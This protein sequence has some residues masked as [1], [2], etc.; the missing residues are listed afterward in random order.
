MVLSAN[1]FRSKMQW[2]SVLI[3]TQI[4]LSN[5]LFKKGV[6]DYGN[7]NSTQN[8]DVPYPS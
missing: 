8:D 7:Q 4:Q 2:L 1:Q 5:K 6:V 3:D